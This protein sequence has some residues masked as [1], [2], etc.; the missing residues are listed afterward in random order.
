MKNVV[1]QG[2]FEIENRKIRLDYKKSH[3]ISKFITKKY[4][5]IA[6]IPLLTREHIYLN[7]N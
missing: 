5:N 1:F 4:P 2:L 7:L 6:V 3:K